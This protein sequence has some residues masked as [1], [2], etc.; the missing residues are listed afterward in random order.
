MNKEIYIL[1]TDISSRLE[2]IN[3]LFYESKDYSNISDRTAH[4][5]LGELNEFVRNILDAY[6]E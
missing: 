1:F 5:K 2:Q 3:I 4:Y 6:E